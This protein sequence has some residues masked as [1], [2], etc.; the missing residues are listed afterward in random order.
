MKNTFLFLALL[1]AFS[2]KNQ[3]ETNIPQSADYFIFGTAHGMCLGDCVTLFKLKGQ[4]LTADDNAQYAMLGS[5]DLPFQTTSLPAEKVALAETLRAQIPANLFKEPDGNIGCPDCYDQGLYFV[6]IKT[7]D[8]VRD[9]RIDRDSK[10]Y[11]AFCE[12]IQTTMEQL[13]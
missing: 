2:C 4:S 5:G 3:P 10:Q 1:L 6:Q 11:A 7:G 8:T 13:K 9:W 12:L